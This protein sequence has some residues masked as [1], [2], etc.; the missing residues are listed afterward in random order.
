MTLLVFALE[1]LGAVGLTRVLLP[2]GRDGRDLDIDGLGRD[3][4]DVETGLVA[5]LAVDLEGLS[6][7]S[8]RQSECR[9]EHS[10]QVGNDLH[11]ALLL[12]G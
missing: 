12:L 4:L 9:D 2:H 1:A 8:S 10:D 11:G 3:I 6:G 7:G 5:A